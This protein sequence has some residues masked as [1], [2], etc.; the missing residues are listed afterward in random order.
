MA[1]FVLYL[2]GG[3][4][5]SRPCRFIFREI[6]HGTHSLGGW[7]SRGVNLDAVEKATYVA[8]AEST[9]NS[10]TVQPVLLSLI[11]QPC[12]DHSGLK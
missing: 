11:W 3:W 12:C 10:S 8:H 1:P 7:V 9:R 2:I 6:A 4:S 5:A